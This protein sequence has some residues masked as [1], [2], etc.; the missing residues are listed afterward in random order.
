M[1]KGFTLIEVLISLVIISFVAIAVSDSFVNGLRLF[2]R[3]VDVSKETSGASTYMENYLN[4]DTNLTGISIE[5][6]EVTINNI[7][8]TMDEVTATDGNTSIRYYK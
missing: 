1:R 7:I 2:K 4:D 8:L 3:S 6:I 5:A